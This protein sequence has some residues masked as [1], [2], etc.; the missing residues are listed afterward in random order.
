LNIISKEVFKIKKKYLIM[1]SALLIVGLLALSGCS[2]GSIGKKISSNIDAQQAQV[3]GNEIG[4]NQALITNGVSKIIIG[5]EVIPISTQHCQS[6]NCDN[7]GLVICCKDGT[8]ST[9]LCCTEGSG[10]P[11]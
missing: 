10:S 3:G 9:R 11:L 8:T 7:E 5:D 6:Y 1:F 2:Q 4:G